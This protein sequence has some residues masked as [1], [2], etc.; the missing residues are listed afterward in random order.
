MDDEKILDRYLIAKVAH[1]RKQGRDAGRKIRQETYLTPQWL[2]AH[3][4]KSCSGC[5]DCLTFEI[6]GNQVISNLTADR[7][8][9]GLD[10]STDNVVP[11][12]CTC[13]QRKAG[14]S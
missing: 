1:Y 14:W 7:F 5:G 2:K 3:Y 11:F 10:H 13:N 8:D 12:C 9:N 4:G 6:D